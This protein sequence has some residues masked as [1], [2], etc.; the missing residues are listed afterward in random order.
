MDELLSSFSS[1]ELDDAMDELLSSFSSEE[2]DD[3]MDE[4]LFSS[5]SEEL[6]NTIDEYSSKI[7]S[8]ELFELSSPH[9]IRK[10]N[11]VSKKIFFISNHSL[12]YN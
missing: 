8:S 12:L 6:D 1:E 2:V 4:P 3:A 9:D 10:V 5:S 7:D 11:N